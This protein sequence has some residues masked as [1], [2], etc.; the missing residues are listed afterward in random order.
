LPTEAR[1]DGRVFSANAAR[2]EEP[3]FFAAE[4]CD[5]ARREG[6][7]AAPRDVTAALELEALLGARA[8]RA[9]VTRD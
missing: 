1:D 5:G 6:A 4:P 2:D 8:A 9:R 7:R 3:R